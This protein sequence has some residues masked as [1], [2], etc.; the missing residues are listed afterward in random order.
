[1]EDL[2]AYLVGIFSV[3]IILYRIFVLMIPMI[4]TSI[5]KNDIPQIF[6]AL[7]LLV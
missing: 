2:L 6:R 5:I 7:S 1:M 4:K 3:L